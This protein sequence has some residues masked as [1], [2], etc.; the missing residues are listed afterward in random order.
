VGA[1]VVGTGE[2]KG[3]AVGLGLRGVVRRDGAR[4]G[5]RI[6]P[7]ADAVGIDVG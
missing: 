5:G 1:R 7:G 6:I 3:V 4:E 2:S